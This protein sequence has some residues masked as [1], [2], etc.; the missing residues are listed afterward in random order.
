MSNISGDPAAC[1]VRK[2]SPEEDGNPRN[3]KQETHIY[4]QRRTP[5]G[6][7]SSLL[8]T[9]TRVNPRSMPRHGCAWLCRGSL[10][11]ELSTSDSTIALQNI[12]L[13][14]DQRYY[15]AGVRSKGIQ[16]STKAVP[17]MLGK[18]AYQEASHAEYLWSKRPV[19]SQH[20]FEHRL[21]CAFTL[22]HALAVHHSE[23]EQSHR[24]ASLRHKGRRRIPQLHGS[25]RKQHRCG[26]RRTGMTYGITTTGVAT[27]L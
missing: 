3:Q 15:G 19:I 20:A 22:S 10:P 12:T 11:D 24:Q 16:Y 14:P 26:G 1:R 17:T 4:A 2:H 25:N 27:V 9:A 23:G 5:A 8:P 7:C 13:Q 18:S 6:T 21:V